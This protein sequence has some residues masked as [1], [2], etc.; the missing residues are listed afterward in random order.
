MNPEQ[1]AVRLKDKVFNVKTLI[2]FIVS[3][4]ILYLLFSRVS[5]ADFLNSLA[6]VNLPLY[7]LAF[8]IYYLA[9]PL[10]G[11]RWKILLENIGLRKGV[12]PLTGIIFLSWFA[13]TLVP[14]KLGDV[15]RGYLCK[16]NYGLS[17][18]KSVGTVFI[19]RVFDVVS[20]VLLFGISGFAIFGTHLPQAI[21][22]SLV[23]GALIV[24]LIALLIFIIKSRILLGRLPERIETYFSEFRAGTSSIGA[25]FMRV[26]S[27]TFIIWLLESASLYVVIISAGLDV[28]LQVAVFTA[29]A[30]ALLTALPLTPAGLGTVEFAI[31]GILSIIGIQAEA[32]LTVAI[33]NRVI[34]YWSLLF[35]GFIAFVF[36][37]MK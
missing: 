18:S 37:D 21:Y 26:A 4:L 32:G 28:P 11:L 12:V 1:G 24:I 25:G 33:L 8:F 16:K 23:M 2:S 10:R 19:E 34:G 17:I 5:L 27:L 30:S 7:L 36:T 29:M 14:A 9:F 6:R 15:Y 3:F 13:N 31:V 20:L 22:A 35:F